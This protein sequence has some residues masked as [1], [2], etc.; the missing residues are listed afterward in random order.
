MIFISISANPVILGNGNKVFVSGSNLSISCV[1]NSSTSLSDDDMQELK[2]YD[3]NGLEFGGSRKF[4][5]AY[6]RNSRSSVT[7]TLSKVS[8][9]RS[10]AGSYQCKYKTGAPFLNN[11]II[12][13]CEYLL[14]LPEL[15]TQMSFSDRPLSVVYLFNFYLTQII[16]R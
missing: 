13:V 2:F 7:I 5:K 6:T 8:V 9:D 14:S 11:V 4:S 12:V 15:K 16:L 3:K 10:D 1:Y